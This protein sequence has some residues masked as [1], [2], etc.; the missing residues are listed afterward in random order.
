MI[1]LWHGV[2]SSPLKLYQGRIIAAADS[3]MVEVFQVQQLAT[4]EFILSVTYYLDCNTSRNDG[5][6]I[7]WRRVGDDNPFQVTAIASGN[8]QRLSF[9]DLN[10]SSLG[11]YECFD[12]L[13]GDSAT[14]NITRGELFHF[15]STARLLLIKLFNNMT[16]IQLESNY[17]V[18]LGIRCMRAKLTI[19]ALCINLKYVIATL[20]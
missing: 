11:R 12:T 17:Y 20:S 13:S 6:G 2:G 1:T 18:H 10:N 9:A 8:G 3:V 7:M 4:V 16:M 19:R 5:S 15:V 14:V